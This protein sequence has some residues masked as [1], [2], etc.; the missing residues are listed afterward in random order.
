MLT[1]IPGLLPAIAK[2]LPAIDFSWGKLGQYTLAA[3]RQAFRDNVLSEVEMEFLLLLI[4]GFAV[5]LKDVIKQRISVG[6]LKFY[7][8]KLS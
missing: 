8:R 3:L 6:Y 2:H 7:T 5:S 4:T 1:T